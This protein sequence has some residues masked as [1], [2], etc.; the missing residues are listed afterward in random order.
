VKTS[1]EFK[2]VERVAQ[3]IA[4]HRM[5]A[6]VSDGELLIA[7]EVELNAILREWK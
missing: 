1:A 6:K 3:A 4:G 7:V 2:K 5:H